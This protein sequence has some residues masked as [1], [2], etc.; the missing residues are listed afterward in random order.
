[1]SIARTLA[2]AAVVLAASMAPAAAQTTPQAEPVPEAS[3]QGSVAVAAVPVLGAGFVLDGVWLAPG[4]A[5][6]G[7]DDV[8][9]SVGYE[10]MHR[11]PDGWRLLSERE[12]SGDVSV[13]FEGSS[14]TVGGL[15]V[16]GVEWW[17]AVR[18]RNSFGVSEWSPAAAVR[19]PQRFD[20]EPL[21]DPFTAPTR[22]GIDL[23]RLREA[24]ATVTPGEADCAAAPTLDVEGVMVVDP[25]AGLD[26]PDA[27]LTVAEVVRVAAAV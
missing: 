2:T 22:S 23:E 1:M 6:L 10:L 24:V 21:F 12:P 15:P 20:V 13:A 19:A 8:A 3:G 14:A 25:P 26:D 18:A 5:S 4:V 17:F 27:V 7:W 11:G 9:A 16:D